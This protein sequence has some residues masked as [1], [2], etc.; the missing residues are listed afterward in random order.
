MISE[1]LTHIWRLPATWPLQRVDFSKTL[2]HGVIKKYGYS[3]SEIFLNEVTTTSQQI[4]FWTVLVQTDSWRQMHWKLSKHLELLSQQSGVTSL[5]A[6]IFSNTSV[7]ASNLTVQVYI[8]YWSSMTVVFA[9]NLSTLLTTSLKKTWKCSKLKVYEWHEQ[10][11]VTLTVKNSWHHKALITI[12]FI[13]CLCSCL[14]HRNLNMIIYNIIILRDFSFLQ[15][16]C[17][18]FIKPSGTWHSVIGHVVPVASRDCRIWTFRKINPRLPPK[19]RILWNI[20]NNSSSDTVS[21]P[22]RLKSLIVIVCV[23]SLSLQICLASCEKSKHWMYLRL[24]K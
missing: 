19:M 9:M 2:N 14:I 10:V 11:K 18:R 13:Q 1:H 17:W 16:H 12:Q 24:R 21:H 3:N 7:T 23:V 5:K 20:E 6:Y 8:F 15:Q 4:W 22:R